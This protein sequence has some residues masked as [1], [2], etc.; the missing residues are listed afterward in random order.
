MRRHFSPKRPYRWTMWRRRSRR[1]SRTPTWRTCRAARR[2]RCSSSTTTSR[3]ARST[4]S[5]TCCRASCWCWYSFCCLFLLC[6]RLTPCHLPTNSIDHANRQCSRCLIRAAL[7]SDLSV[8]WSSGVYR[9]D[10]RYIHFSYSDRH[11]VLVKMTGDCCRWSSS[12]NYTF[13]RWRQDNTSF[14]IFEQKIFGNTTAIV[15][16]AVFTVS[17]LRVLC[18]HMS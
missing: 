3:T 7:K 16:N 13:R 17:V 5:C 15:I 9:Q 6:Q 10:R 4:V 18:Y 8:S 11:S 14:I 2:S 1:S 12:C